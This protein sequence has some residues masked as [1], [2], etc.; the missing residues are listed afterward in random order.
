MLIDSL[1]L[2]FKEVASET[3]ESC[4]SSVINSVGTTK[5]DFCVVLAFV[6]IVFSLATV[7]SA[8]TCC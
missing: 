8:S 5:V 7:S 3:T 6:S 4:V 1:W 2:V